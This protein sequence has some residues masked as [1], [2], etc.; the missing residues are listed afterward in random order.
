MPIVGQAAVE[1][2]SQAMFLT[3]Q[4]YGFPDELDSAQGI[5]LYRQN[6][7]FDL[8]GNPYI[9]TGPTDGPLVAGRMEVWQLRW[10]A[11]YRTGDEVR[12]VNS[13]GQTVWSS[14]ARQ[15]LPETDDGVQGQ[16]WTGARVSVMQSGTLF[17]TYRQFGVTP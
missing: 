3:V 15:G 14:V 2:T 6:A 1:S 12:I 8:T 16:I 11:P 10:V 4:P 5:G 7:H 9:I 17:I 13:S